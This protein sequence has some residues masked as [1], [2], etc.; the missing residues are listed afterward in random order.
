M[1]KNE[2]SELLNLNVQGYL[3]QCLD[4]PL[5]GYLLEWLDRAPPR[6]ISNPLRIPSP[7]HA[8]HSSAVPTARSKRARRATEDNYFGSS[9]RRTA[10]ASMTDDLG[11]DVEVREEPHRPRVTFG[12][13]S[14][15]PMALRA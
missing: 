5:S 8:S 1:K 2:N 11:F 7:L 10:C 15:V 3:F 4:D 14:S 13:S 9:R 12:I 6:L